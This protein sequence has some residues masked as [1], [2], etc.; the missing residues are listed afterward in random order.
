[1]E[2]QLNKTFGALSDATR[3]H[4]L[5]LLVERDMA[6]TEIADRFPLTLAG[7][8][9]HLAVLTRAGLV[10][11]RRRGRE[12]WCGIEPGGLRDAFVW[13]QAFG[14]FEATAYDALESVLDGLAAAVDDLEPR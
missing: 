6:V 8:S 3:R 2:E 4:M 13:M 12:I 11:R 10:S 1:M 5:S 14:H 7:V 9:K